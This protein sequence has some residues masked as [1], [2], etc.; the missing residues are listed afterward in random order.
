MPRAARQFSKTGFYHIMMRGINRERIFEKE[1]AKKEML[2]TLATK[3]RETDVGIYAY[4]VMDNHIHLLLKSEP[5]EL[6]VFMKKLNGS[7]AMYYNRE[8]RR[9]GHVFQDRYKSERVEDEEYFWGVTR[10]IH[11]N[12]VKAHLT[13]NAEDYQW[14]SMKD[15]LLGKSDVLA[16][17]ALALK[18]DNFKDN[19]SFLEM[20]EKEDMHIYLEIKE[21]LD[22][23]KRAASYQLINITLAEHGV[24]KV[25]DLREQEEALETLL[26]RLAREVKLSYQEIAKLTGLS[27][28]M[29]QR[30]VQ[31]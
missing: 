28:S 3:I 24:N 9:V 14:S 13:K 16:K 30:L 23:M 1:A 25:V 2:H 10:Y 8:Q 19:K 29:V 31:R 4:C 5:Q 17:E 26:V 7:F 6:A 12:P 22:E 11:L 21:E 18:Q 27:Y 20:H 15:F